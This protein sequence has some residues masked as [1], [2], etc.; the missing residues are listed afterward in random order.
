MWAIEAMQVTAGG[1]G[2]QDVPH[3]KGA[4]RDTAE[5]HFCCCRKTFLETIEKSFSIHIL[6]NNKKLYGSRL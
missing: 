3:Q 4:A 2:T 6:Y 5:P 1:S